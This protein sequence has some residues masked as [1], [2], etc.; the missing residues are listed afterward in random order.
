MAEGFFRHYGNGKV[1]A[2]SA[3]IAP[4]GVN[5]IATKVMLEAG[6]DISG[7]TSDNLKIYL[8]DSFDY[9]IT[10]CDNAKEACPNFSGAEY[11]LHWPFDDPY[12]AS[13]TEDE[14]LSEFRRV[15]DEI[16]QRIKTWLEQQ[17]N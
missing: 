9:V 1:D 17:R 5:E 14:I 16:G 10:V 8:K 3:G 7:Q 15:R 12:Y 11:T 6:V 4:I 2:F 13:G